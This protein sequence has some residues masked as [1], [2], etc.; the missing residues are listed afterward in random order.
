MDFRSNGSDF[1]D[2]IKNAY[3]LVILFWRGKL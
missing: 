2:N 3:F 1:Q